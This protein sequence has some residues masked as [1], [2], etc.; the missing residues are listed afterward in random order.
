ME[1][2]EE[3]VGRS[4]SEASSSTPRRMY[5][6]RGEREGERDEKMAAIRRKS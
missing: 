6:L 2:Q 3:K 5:M 4:H 1:L